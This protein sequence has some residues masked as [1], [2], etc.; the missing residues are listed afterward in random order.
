[1]L[2]GLMAQKPAEA[3]ERFL[4]QTAQ[5]VKDLRGRLADSQQQFGERLRVSIRTVAR[6][7]SEGI[8]S[9]GV[10]VQ[11]SKLAQSKGIA[12][13][14]IRF[15]S[16]AVESLVIDPLSDYWQPEYVSAVNRTHV[17]LMHTQGE[18]Y[19]NLLRGLQKQ[20]VTRE[21][22]RRGKP[23]TEQERRL[24]GLS[25]EKLDTNLVE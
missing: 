13:L 25:R 18:P 8:I 4:A 19:L 22:E 15:K 9:P 7:E 3:L 11:L 21:V 14:A 24:L 2:G 10:L 5:A 6:W 1:M 16:Y 20:M 17:W 12:E 23:L